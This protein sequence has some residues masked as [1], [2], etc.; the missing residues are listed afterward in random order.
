MTNLSQVTKISRVVYF[1]PL[2][3]VLSGLSPLR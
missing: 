1:Y 2:G 3:G